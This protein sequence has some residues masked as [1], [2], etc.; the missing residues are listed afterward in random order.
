MYVRTGKRGDT[1]P[2]TGAEEVL[3]GPDGG[4]RRRQ[5]ATAAIVG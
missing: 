5:Y 2:R 4:G 1:G 3:A